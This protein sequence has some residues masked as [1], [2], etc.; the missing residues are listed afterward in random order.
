MAGTSS[1]VARRTDTAGAPSSGTVVGAPPAAGGT[2]L[3]NHVVPSKARARSSLWRE[4]S[5]RLSGRA[6]GENQPTSSDSSSPTRGSPDSWRHR[7]H[8]SRYCATSPLGYSTTGMTQALARPT[9]LARTP[10][11][12]SISRTSASAGC[13]PGSRIPEIRAHCPLSE[14]RPSSTS[15]AR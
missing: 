3:S 8:R 9:R 11:S 7:K 4:D 10:V 5:D 1:R 2:A 15:P 13:S 14:R 12:S 6:S